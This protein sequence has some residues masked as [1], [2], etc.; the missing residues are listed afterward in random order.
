MSSPDLQD[1]RYARYEASHFGQLRE[2]SSRPFGERI[3]APNTTVTGVCPAFVGLCEE[4][5]IGFYMVWPMLFSDRQEQVLGGQPMDSMVHPS[6]QGKG[7][8][9]ELA[10]RCYQLC[11][12]NKDRRHVWSSQPRGIRRQRR[13]A[14]LLSRL[15][16]SRFG[17]PTG[18]DVV[19]RDALGRTGGQVCDS[20]GSDLLECVAQLE[21][22]HPLRGARSPQTKLV[23][24]SQGKVA[25]LPLSPRSRRRILYRPC[26]RRARSSR[27]G[28]LRILQVPS[29]SKPQPVYQSGATPPS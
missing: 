4:Q 12:E 13:G 16:C 10:C 18:A 24:Q 21:V 29:S 14:E 9:R 11:N 5:V 15:Q 26:A 25:Q 28:G 17:A 7:M 19:P 3:E 27:S 23:G 6:F 22:K 8:L 1:V 2:L 20:A